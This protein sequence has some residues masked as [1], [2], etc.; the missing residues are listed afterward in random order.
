MWRGACLNRRAKGTMRPMLYLTLPSISLGRCARLAALVLFCAAGTGCLRVPLPIIE[1]DINVVEEAELPSIPQ[2]IETDPRL[3]VI[4]LEIPL[5]Y[6][7]D[8]GEVDFLVRAYLDQVQEDF[9]GEFANN[10]D[11]QRVIIREIRLTAVKGDFSFIAEA[12]IRLIQ[13]REP[14]TYWSE[15]TNRND[16][17]QLIL[18]PDGDYNLFDLIPGDNDCVTADLIY[19]GTFPE[20]PVVFNLDLV[21]AVDADLVL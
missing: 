6:L 18:R 20:R 5:P 16:K 1:I 4:G 3:G 12:G 10:L 13:N 2:I 14:I 8:L 17:K 7:C 15:F 21:I 11:L 9:L 19:S